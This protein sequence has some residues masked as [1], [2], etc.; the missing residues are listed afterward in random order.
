MFL[1]RKHAFSVAR[2]DRFEKL[3]N[4]PS[5][6]IVE[7]FVERPDHPPHVRLMEEATGRRATVAVSMLE[8]GSYRRLGSPDDDLGADLL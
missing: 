3:G 4:R 5:A 8:S 6:W 2:G 1:R 7:E